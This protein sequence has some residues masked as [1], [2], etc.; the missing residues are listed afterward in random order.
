MRVVVVVV[1]LFGG[2]GRVA[3]VA[4]FGFCRFGCFGLCWCWLVGFVRFLGLLVRCW[5]A[6]VFLVVLGVALGLFPVVV[7]LRRAGLP[8]WWCLRVAAG[9]LG[10]LVL[11]GCLVRFGCLRFLRCL[12]RLGLRVWAFG[13]FGLRAGLGVAGVFG[14]V[15]GLLVRGCGFVG[16][17]VGERVIL[18]FLGVFQP[19]GHPHTNN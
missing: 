13:L 9:F 15:V 10:L 12:V 14:G 5:L 8:V 4:G 7:W 17:F 16:R 11:L 1:F 19:D 18:V 3:V 6:G 2:V